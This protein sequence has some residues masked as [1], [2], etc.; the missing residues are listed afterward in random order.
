VKDGAQSPSSAPVQPKGAPGRPEVQVVIQQSVSA[1]AV[2]L[3]FGIT[4]GDGNGNP[5]SPMTLTY[6]SPWGDGTANAA[7]QFELTLPMTATGTVTVRQTAADGSYSTG[8][9]VVQPTLSVDTA[10]A[11]LTVRYVPEK[12]LYCEVLSGGSSLATGQATD[13]P[14]GSPSYNTYQYSYEGIAVGTDITI[15][16]G[17]DS[18]APTTYQISTTR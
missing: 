13:T 8:T 16:C 10:T 7:N 18:A 17:G 5:P 9:L 12:P 14:D 3:L 11:V 6:S 4:P 15:Q 1:G 2:T